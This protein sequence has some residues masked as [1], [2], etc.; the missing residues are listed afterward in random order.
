LEWRNVDFAAG[1]VR[2]DPGT[3]KNGQGRVIKMTVELRA[4][5][6]ARSAAR[7]A[8]G[9][10]KLK[11]PW[12]FWRLLAKGKRSRNGRRGGKNAYRGE[13]PT[14]I[15][16]F[17][18]AWKAACKAAGCPGRIPHD[19]R[20]TA[21]RNFIRAGIPQ[22][23]AKTLTGHLTDSVFNRYNITSESDL[24][25]AAQRMSGRHVVNQ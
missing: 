5:L 17:G 8:L 18:K 7:D 25:D 11:V 9:D 19:L 15:T 23:V 20:R 16:T 21:V 2:L 1:E 6:E 4:L 24:V 14:R 22:Q 10:A 13:E 3:T 12:V